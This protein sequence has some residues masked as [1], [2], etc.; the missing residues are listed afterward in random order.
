[1]NR[2]QFILRF[3][4]HRG[5]VQMGLETFIH[6][7]SERSPKPFRLLRQIK[8]DNVG[9]VISQLLYFWLRNVDQWG[10]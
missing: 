10:T 9:N 4:E 1:M 2:P 5:E 3:L 8:S 7:T 6:Q